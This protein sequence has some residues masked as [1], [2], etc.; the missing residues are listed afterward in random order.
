MLQARI[1]IFG[2]R[3]VIKQQRDGTSDIVHVSVDI[4]NAVIVGEII[5]KEQIGTGSYLQNRF[6]KFVRI[7]VGVA[8]MAVVLQCLCDLFTCFSML[9]VKI[10]CHRP[11]LSSNL[12]TPA[13]CKYVDYIVA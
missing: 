5:D 10:K 2:K 1:G 11:F 3:T 6:V 9:R 12:C 13:C 4:E 8:R 7:Y